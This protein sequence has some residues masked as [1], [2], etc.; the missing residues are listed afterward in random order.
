MKSAHNTSNLWHCVLCILEAIRNSTR[1]LQ[2][3]QLLR[4]ESHHHLIIACSKLAHVA[5]FSTQSPPYETK[6]HCTLKEH[7]ADY[8][9]PWPRLGPPRPRLGPPPP[10]GFFLGADGF[11]LGAGGFLA[12]RPPPPVPVLRFLAPSCLSASPGKLEP[13]RAVGTA[14]VA[15]WI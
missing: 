12:P 15:V 2:V 5:S 6:F 9:R 3:P 8:A 13:L 4:G 1:V 7:L 11:F 14:G 10:R